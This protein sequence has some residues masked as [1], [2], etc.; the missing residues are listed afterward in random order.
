MKEVSGEAVE[1]ERSL[2]RIHGGGSRLQDPYAPYQAL[3]ATHGCVRVANADAEAISQI[4]NDFGI[5]GDDYVYVGTPQYLQTFSLKDMNLRIMLNQEQI[6]QR[7][8]A[9]SFEKLFL[10]FWRRGEEESRGSA[11]SKICFGEQCR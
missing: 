2:I 3:V 5:D 6:F 1:S 9:N 8:I 4:L 11:E 7:R 10:E